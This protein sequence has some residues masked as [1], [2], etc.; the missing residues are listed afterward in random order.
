MSGEEGQGETGRELEGGKELENSE[1]QLHES[2]SK[3]S[4]IAAVHCDVEESTAKEKNPEATSPGAAGH[5]TGAN[6]SACQEQ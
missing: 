6:D 3:L 5:L 4:R 1:P 2:T